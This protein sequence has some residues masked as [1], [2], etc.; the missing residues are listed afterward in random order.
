[1][2]RL[3]NLIHVLCI[4]D[5]ADVPKFGDIYNG[6]YPINYV[7]ASTFILFQ[8]LLGSILKRQINKIRNG[9]K[10]DSN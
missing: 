2:R 1:M 9:R 7:D 6:V 10:A 4:I 8:L 5:E 3:G